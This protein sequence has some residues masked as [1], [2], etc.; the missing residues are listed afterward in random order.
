[1]CSVCR[2]YLQVHTILTCFSQQ[3]GSEHG[4]VPHTQKV[5]EVADSARVVHK[6]FVF[7]RLAVCS[8]ENSSLG[9][10]GWGGWQIRRAT[11]EWRSP[12]I[13]EFLGPKCSQPSAGFGLLA[14]AI[15]IL[16]FPGRVL[17]PEICLFRSFGLR[18]L[19]CP[20]FPATAVGFLSSFF[21]APP[22]VRRTPTRY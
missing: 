8:T 11:A 4:R 7:N 10:V 16:A 1:M 5:R 14:A 13:A 22:S 20:A 15:S 21:P 9:M 19:G 17:R 2:R 6:F 12:D 3:S 18:R